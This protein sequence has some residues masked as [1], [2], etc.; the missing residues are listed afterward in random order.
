L[1]PYVDSL[2][3]PPAIQALPGQ[4]IEIRM[5]EALHKAHRDLNPGRVWGYNGTWPGPSI[6]VK[7]GQALTVRWINNLPSRHLF[8]IDH[9]LHGAESSLPE[10]RNVVHLHGAQ[11]LPASDGYPESWISPDGRKGPTFV[12]NHCV[13]PNEQPAT[14]LWYHDHAIGI[15]R[16][17]VYAGLTGFYIIEDEDEARLNLPH[18]AYDIPLMLQDR[19]FAADGSISYPVAQ[20]GT[21]PVWVQEDFGD[22]NCVNGKVTPYLEVEP[23]R[24]RFRLLNASNSRF[25]HLTLVPSDEEGNVI[26]KAREAP[27]FS[28]I[29]TD[30][31]LLPSP[32]PL[33][34]L[35]ISPAERCDIVID[36]S[37]HEGKQFAVINDAAAPYPRG[38]K[39]VTREVMLFKVNKAL[40]GKD[41]S[42]L[43][44]ALIPVSALN[45]ADAVGERFLAVTEMDRASD[46]YTVMGLLGNKHWDDPVTENPKAGSTEIWSFLNTTG[47]V[48]PIHIHLVR[49]QVLNR[50]AFDVNSYLQ[51]GK[52][53]YSGIPVAPEANERPAWKDTVK[54]YPGMITRVI[55]K[56]DLPAGASV[57]HASAFRYVWHCHMLEH[58]DNDMMRPFD[59]IV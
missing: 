24:Y 4:H 53:V 28:Q 56:F 20:N 50:Q 14:T 57:E 23:R 5:R 40:S 37:G 35:V 6:K 18:G 52:V 29:G 34:Y 51:S 19:S 44:E 9:T 30:S 11:V 55:A 33:H 15:N 54:T 58:E 1:K 42:S 12:S 8:A 32:L 38:G 31:G 3:I 27:S 17:N 25:Y 26:G 21:H 59:V 10:V 49:F 22:V 43:P 48:H 46:G 2:T 41:S 13:Y 16:L 36:F 39:S 45:P 7:R 47:D